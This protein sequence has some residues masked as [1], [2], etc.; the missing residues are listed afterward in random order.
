MMNSGDNPELSGHTEDSLDQPRVTPEDE[1]AHV[2]ELDRCEQWINSRGLKRVSLQFPDSL[3]QDAP[4]VARLL[5]ARVDDNVNIFILGDTTYGECCV[6]EIAAEHVSS[7][8]V[9]HFG[10]TCLTPACRLPA[11]LIFTKKSL[12]LSQL[13][14]Q[15]EEKFSGKSI[16]LIY[17]VEYDHLLNTYQPSSGSNVKLLVGRCS[18]VDSENSEEQTCL[19]KFGRTFNVTSE[20]EMEGKT[21]LFVGK[22]ESVL[23]NFIYSWTENEFY[24]FENQSFVPAGSSISKFM[25]KR[26]FLVEKTKDAERIGLL[27]GTL[28]ADKYVEII[29]KLKQTGRKANKK[30]YVF[31]VGKPNVAKLANFPEIDVFVLV[32]CPETC[33]IDGKDYLQPIITPFEFEIACGKGTQWSGKL[34]TDYRDILSEN[35]NG[36]END[37]SEDSDD[38]GDISLIT[39]KIRTSCKTVSNEESALSVINDKTISLLHEG[40]GG[41][42]LAGRSWSG[43]E[44]KLGQTPVSEVTQG[45]MGVAAGYKGEGQK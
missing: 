16:V 5:K 36:D 31:L 4:N 2:Y 14:D 10:H 22:R 33:L 8:S 27:V 38:E 7:D 44:Q 24:V 23:M 13:S 6:D 20:N 17:D 9:I 1:I 32:A 25:M 29:E 12:D 37:S 39:G 45:R 34:V 42:F 35:L 15:I 21:I 28:G 18:Y 43:L 30:V 11:L 40:G 3:L 26:Y 19:R 41:S